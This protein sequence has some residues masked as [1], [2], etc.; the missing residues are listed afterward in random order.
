M[1]TWQVRSPSDVVIMKKTLPAA[2]KEEF[3]DEID[4]YEIESGIKQS[5]EWSDLGASSVALR[6]AL[7]RARRRPCVR[8]DMLGHCVHA[9]V[10]CVREVA[11]DHLF[12]CGALEHV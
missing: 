8:R 6:C 5:T 2:V 3:G 12:A 7:S 11:F 4:W 9:P 1:L 10:R